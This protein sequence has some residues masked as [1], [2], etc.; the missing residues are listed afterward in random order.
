MKRAALILLATGLTPLLAQNAKPKSTPVDAATAFAIASPDENS[1]FFMDPHAAG[2]T[3]NVDY[4]GRDPNDTIA[5]YPQ[6]R[7]SSGSAMAQVKEFFGGMFSSVNFGPIRT[8][9]TTEKL[10]VDPAK[11]SLQ[12]R[13]EVNVTYTIRNNT[14]KITRLEYPT[15]QRIDILTYDPK[16]I[17]IDRW[18]DDRAFQPED[19]IV[20][21]N[22]KERIEY[23]EKIPTR[24]MK[25]GESYRVETFTTSTEKFGS[26]V[27]ITPE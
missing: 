6:N 4:A 10:E 20:V 21:I 16:G 27:S 9:P 19:G 26:Q 15:T 22:P 8:P 5:G 23:Q 17:V 18:S 13:R 3:R 14:K 24:E 25:A 11:F 12:D 2:R 7:N 1:P